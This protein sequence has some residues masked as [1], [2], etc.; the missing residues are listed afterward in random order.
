MILP[1]P[2]SSP[3]C[4]RNNMAIKLKWIEFSSTGYWKSAFFEK[5]YI[6]SRFLLTR[7]PS[8]SVGGTPDQKEE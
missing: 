4:N 2:N 8:G 3:T 5:D 1:F 6:E 7:F